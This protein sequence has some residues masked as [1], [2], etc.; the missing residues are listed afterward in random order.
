MP[1]I[2]PNLP[3]DELL[4]LLM[5]L[6]PEFS[7]TR[8][9]QPVD[10]GTQSTQGNVLQDWLDIL[11][12]PFLGGMVAG[13][14]DPFSSQG[15]PIELPDPIP[16]PVISTPTIDRFLNSGNQW[17]QMVAESIKG[18]KPEFQIRDELR[19]LVTSGQMSQEVFDDLVPSI[20]AM[21][22]EQADAAVAQ[23]TYDS[24]VAAQQQG[25]AQ[26][27]AQPSPY[28]QQFRKAGLPSPTEQYTPEV[29]NPELPQLADSLAQQRGSMQDAL[30]RYL[31]ERS[32]GNIDSMIPTGAAP[33]PARDVRFLDR[34]VDPS[35]L[36]GELLSQ[37]DVDQRR[38]AFGDRRS[39]VGDARPG[40]PATMRVPK[41]DRSSGR[42][43]LQH[44]R[45]ARSIADAAK[46][47]VN[48]RQSNALDRYHQEMTTV[49][50]S[51]HSEGRA[52]A[53][54][55]SA[56]RFASAQGR[57]PFTD[58]IQQRVMM[59]KSLGL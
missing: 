51:A 43:K 17:A 33:Q 45:Q 47:K 41:V 50:N 34:Q 37:R 2:D 26:Q 55:E 38:Y 53:R 31:S 10:I 54:A 8:G 36:A 7:A 48:A 52:R 39:Q 58:A 49:A 19:A 59:L 16:Q 42:V 18:G 1:P 14:T 46:S 25:I 22:K 24:K 20:A 40:A 30:D 32:L 27:Q 12:D 6:Q 23:A 35:A 29:F 9:W 57:T 4:P 11:S 56:A 44:D 13:G 3:L 15:A 21:E 5:M 28:D